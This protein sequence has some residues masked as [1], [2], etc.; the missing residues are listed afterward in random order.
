MAA[1]A[2]P[3]VIAAPGLVTPLPAASGVHLF[4]APKSR[5]GQ[6]GV[7]QMQTAVATLKASSALLEYAAFLA[8]RVAVRKIRIAAVGT[9][10]RATS[11]SFWVA[12]DHAAL[13]QISRSRPDY[14]IPG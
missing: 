13:V 2:V 3:I 10:T 5:M 11:A 14:F 7:R 8:S 12:L 6:L 1:N 4:P 9:R